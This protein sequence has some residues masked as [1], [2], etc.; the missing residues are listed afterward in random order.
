MKRIFL[1]SVLLFIVILIFSSQ[2]ERFVVRLNNPSLEEVKYFKTHNYDVASYKPG[3]YLDLVVDKSTYQNLISQGYTLKITQTENQI[4]NNLSEKPID[5]YRSYNDMLAELQQIESLHPDICKLYDIGDSWGKIYYNEGNSNYEDFQ[6]DI[7]ALKI[8]DNV[9][10]EEDEP[11]ILYDGEHHAREPISME[12]VMKIIYHIV[13]NYG[14]DT[15]ITNDVNNK[16]IWFVPLINP[17]GHKL[18][19]DQTN[20]W[21]RKNIRDNN[22]NGTIYSGNTTDNQDG[23]DPNRNYGFEWGDVG[24]TD[25]W[26]GETYH[27]PNAFSEPNIQAMRDLVCAHNFV[28]AISYHSYSELVLFPLGYQNNTIAPD[29]DALEDLAVQM[30][31]TIPSLDGGHYTPQESW[32]LYP[33]MGTSDDYYYG[34][35]GIFA[36]TIELGQEFI[37]V[38]SVMNQIIQDNLTAAMILLDRVDNRVLTG[39]ITDAVTGEPISAQIFVQGVDDTGVY[40]EP[41]LSD[42]TFGRYYRL[43]LPGNYSVTYSKYGYEPLTVTVNITDSGQTIYDPAL[44]PVSNR[45]SFGGIIR[46]SNDFSPLE[47]VEISILNTPFENV[48]TNQNGEFEI[49]DIAPGTY[50]VQIFKQDYTSLN[51]EI[52]FDQDIEMPLFLTPINAEDFENGIP[53]EWNSHLTTNQ[54]H[55]VSDNA[56]S[57]SHSLCS[58]DISDNQTA[59][60]TYQ[61]SNLTNNSYVSFYRKVSSESGYDFL[62]FYIDNQLQ[63][64]W[65]GEKNWEYFIYEVPA[66]THNLSWQYTKDQSV[67]NGSDCAWIDLVMMPDANTSDNEIIVFPQEIVL[68]MLENSVLDSTFSIFNNLSSDVQNISITSSEEWLEIPQNNI[69]LNAKHGKFIDYTVTTTE[70]G[71]FDAN[72][73]IQYNNQTLTIP[74]YLVVSS[75]FSDDTQIPLSTELYNVYPN[76]FMISSKKSNLK[77][78]YQLAKKSQTS[79][80]IF[81]LKGQLIAKL[82][83]GVQT[84]G[85]HSVSWNLKD[86]NGKKISSGIYFY[87]LDSKDKTL[88]KKI[89][90]IK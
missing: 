43:L 78:N 30:A 67:S 34:S 41:R 85:K 11:N 4:K 24:T 88:I 20:Y 64:Q 13:N 80:T 10:I 46:S 32:Q 59:A 86:K 65:S 28:A 14:S 40:V 44:Q 72:I 62:N 56:Y 57:G 73:L 5:G 21:W 22:Q 87:K 6:H 74:V 58:N 70:Q 16:Q 79:L 29:H 69:N 76:P 50:T 61:T 27:G 48:T 12:M 3:V 77:I 19:W 68:E 51:L 37:P 35:R 17:N 38:S 33:C 49:Q 45:F 89:T 31:N 26:T 52:N 81:N 82:T 53:S 23:V 75:A 2:I 54:W 84:A 7:W 42:E 25:E 8:S 83:E 60:F 1:I 55:I 39:H 18:V 63:D 9:E 71:E 90:V 66:G 47:N 15:Q 36:F